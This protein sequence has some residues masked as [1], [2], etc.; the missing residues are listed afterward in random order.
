MLNQT[1]PSAANRVYATQKNGNIYYWNLDLTGFA[2]GSNVNSVIHP[3]TAVAGNFLV[4]IQD[5]ELNQTS[6][7]FTNIAPYALATLDFNGK[8][9]DAIVKKASITASWEIVNSTIPTLN[10][11]TAFG[12]NHALI[13]GTDGTTIEYLSTDPL[14][15]FV[16]VDPIGAL[17]R[18]SGT[19]NSITQAFFVNADKGIAK[20]QGVTQSEIMYTQMVEKIGTILMKHCLDSH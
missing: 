17:I 18:E 15:S 3:N 9:F 5:V 11:L 19:T 4:S 7:S 13:F 1:S 6:T 20:I 16:P 8:V 10:T 14:T 2:T 12:L